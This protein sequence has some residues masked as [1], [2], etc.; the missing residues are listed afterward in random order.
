VQ[1][2]LPETGT[3]LLPGQWGTYKTFCA[4]D[5]AAAVMAGAT[6]IGFQVVRRGGVL[7][8]AAEGASEIAIRLQAVIEAKY[9]D[10][11]R[12]PFA[13][14]DY[15]PRLADAGSLKA[16]AEIAGQVSARIKAQFALPL[17]LIVIDTVVSAAGFTKNGDEN[18]AAVNQAIMTRMA[19][20]SR[21]TGALVLG[22]DHFGKAVETGVRGSSAKEGAADVVLAALGQRD[23]AGQV[24]GTRIAARKRRAGPSGEEFPFSPRVV[25]LGAD[26]NGKPVTSLV[27]DWA[28]QSQRPPV[29]AT[30]PD[31][32]SKSLQL[33]RR[34][35]M[36]VLATDVA[37]NVRPF[38]DGLLV[39]AVDLEIVRT[40]FY[41]SSV[42]DG[43]A[44][45]KQAA[46]RQAFRRAV[47]NAQD[48]NLI[49]K[50]EIDAVTFVWLAKSPPRRNAW[51]SRQRDTARWKKRPA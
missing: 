37:V 11:D 10:T 51:R 49:G 34:A 1:D 38:G 14:A 18:D 7:F 45:Q 21:M 15:C 40:E 31:A 12:A 36:N 22:I 29:G 13:W 6:F 43:D 42:A 27:I 16:L 28:E 41:R 19:E 20:L 3:A 2:L 23:L 47:L 44:A 17:A 30:K 35:M 4:L 48:R 8:V 50:R 25:E 26:A 39:R 46:R 24:S 9:P 33:L 5:L 32:W